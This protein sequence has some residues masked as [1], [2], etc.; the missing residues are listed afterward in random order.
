MGR[1]RDKTFEDA[2]VVAITQLARRRLKRAG[3]MEVFSVGSETEARRQGLDTPYSVGA[4]FGL[5]CEH[6]PPG[7]QNED[8]QSLA[9]EV[10]CD[11]AEV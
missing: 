4:Y 8:L 1:P 2:E 11:G 3:M 10:P 9:I 7:I 6:E 5:Y